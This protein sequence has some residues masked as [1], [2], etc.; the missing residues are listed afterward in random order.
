MTS[1]EYE[2]LAQLAR[3][4]PE[5][6][7]TNIPVVEEGE[8]EGALLEA[9]E[10]FRKNFGR[11]HVPGILKCFSSSPTLL[12]EIMAMSSTLLFSDGHLGRRRKEMI[13]SYVSKLNEC[14]YCLDSHA[15][16]LCVHGGGAMVQPILDDRLDS[17]EISSAERLLLEFVSKVNSAS[18][19]ISIQNVIALRDAGWSDDQIAEAVHVAAMFS[20]FNRVAN[21]FGLI[22]QGLLNLRPAVVSENNANSFEH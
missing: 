7:R 21:A 10:S 19:R 20:F 14:P 3:P 9:Y 17:V 5:Q 1:P 4:N 12:T 15:F 22:S 6:I 13:A 2:F 18:N 16:F 8:A 11:P